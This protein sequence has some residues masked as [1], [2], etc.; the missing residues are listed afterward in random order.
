MSQ[1]NGEMG[2]EGLGVTRGEV[3]GEG[4]GGAE[5]AHSRPAGAAA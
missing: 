5:H 3:T 2:T 4:E 1:K